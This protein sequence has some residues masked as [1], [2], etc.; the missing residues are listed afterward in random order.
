M[1]IMEDR[2]TNHIWVATDERSTRRAPLRNWVLGPPQAPRWERPGL[3]ALLVG[4]AV[5]YLWR[6]GSLGWANEFY[7]AA[8]QAGTQSWKA[9][10][11]GSLDAGIPDAVP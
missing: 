6:L 2:A 9:L 1:T 5:L 3:L 8:V 10:L 4:T 7:A 11:F